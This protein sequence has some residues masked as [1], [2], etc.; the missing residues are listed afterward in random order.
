LD[1]NL[2]IIRHIYQHFTPD[3]LLLKEIG[4]KGRG[5]TPAKVNR[6]YDGLADE[7]FDTIGKL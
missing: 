4:N 3:A 2:T 1:L 7:Y 6:A 5:G